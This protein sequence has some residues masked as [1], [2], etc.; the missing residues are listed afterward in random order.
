M[1]P[2]NTW[3]TSYNVVESYPTFSVLPPTDVPRVSAVSIGPSLLNASNGS[4]IDR[5]WMVTQN[6]NGQVVI[7]GAN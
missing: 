4:L 6:V 3:S 2:N 1:I 7:A 5:Y